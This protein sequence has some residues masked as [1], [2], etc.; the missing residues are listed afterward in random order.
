M[1]RQRLVPPPRRVQRFAVVQGERQSFPF[2][3]AQSSAFQK[4]AAVGVEQ[5][6]PLACQVLKS[7]LRVLC[8]IEVCFRL[9]GS[10]TVHGD[11]IRELADVKIAGN[12]HFPAEAILRELSWHPDALRASTKS[13]EIWR[14]TVVELVQRGYQHV[15]FENVQVTCKSN[16]ETRL[17][18]EIQEGVSINRDWPDRYGKLPLRID[19]LRDGLRRLLPS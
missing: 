19:I 17:S 9:T 6:V 18:A 14:R 8:F 5:V 12:N 11:W 2:W 16:T 4:P 3:L 15:G 13:A 1:V 7:V 10:A